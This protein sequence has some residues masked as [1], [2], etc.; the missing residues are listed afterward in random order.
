MALSYLLSLSV[1]SL[2]AK[3]RRLNYDEK[4]DNPHAD[5]PLYFGGRLYHGCAP[6]MFEEGI[7]QKMLEDMKLST[8]SQLFGLLTLGH[9]WVNESERKLWQGTLDYLTERGNAKRTGEP[10]LFGPS[11]GSA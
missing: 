1:V 7:G 5:N 9:A 8:A 3:W 10:S 2:G 6:M 4:R 11:E